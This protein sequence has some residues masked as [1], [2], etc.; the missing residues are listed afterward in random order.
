MLSDYMEGPMNHHQSD[1]DAVRARQNHHFADGMLLLGVAAA[2][3]MAIGLVTGAVYGYYRGKSVP[4]VDSLL[5][6]KQACGYDPHPISDVAWELYD[7][8]M[9][10]PGTAWYYTGLFKSWNSKAADCMRDELEPFW[11]NR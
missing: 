3:G 1:S 9:I 8:G 7:R 5:P 2:L 6:L 4:Y 11:R 10:P